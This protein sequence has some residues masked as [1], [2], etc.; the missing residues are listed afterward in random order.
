MSALDAASLELDLTAGL[1]ALG[2]HLTALQIAQLCQYAGLISK[3]NKV[4]NLTALREQESILSHHLLDCLAVITPLSNW[5]A[6]K[7]LAT[8]KAKKLPLCSR[9][10]RSYSSK[11]CAYTMPAWKN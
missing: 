11:M 6:D 4:Y 3:W 5:A 9:L 1:Q 8:P 2:L 7:G 10:R